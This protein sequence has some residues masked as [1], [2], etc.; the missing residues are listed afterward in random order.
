MSDLPLAV[1]VY[2]ATLL[3][4]ALLVLDSRRMRRWRDVR[5][6]RRTTRRI[7]ARTQ[8]SPPSQPEDSGA[9]PTSVPAE[10]E[11]SQESSQRRAS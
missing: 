4:A 2:T 6:T 9:D 10:A 11:P 3:S 5:R 7:W 1:L 8:P